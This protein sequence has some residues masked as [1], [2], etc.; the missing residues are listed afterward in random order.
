MGA[1]IRPNLSAVQSAQS[2]YNCIPVRSRYRQRVAAPAAG[3]IQKYNHPR[4]SP[5]SGFFYSRRRFVLSLSFFV[6]IVF[7]ISPFSSLKPF[8]AN[9]IIATATIRFRSIDA[10]MSISIFVVHYT[11]LAPALLIAWIAA[12]CAAIAW[13]I[14][15]VMNVILRL[16]RKNLSNCGTYPCSFPIETI[17]RPLIV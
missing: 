2:K 3:N 6:R 7:R 4:R 9:A 15:S 5:D 17:C 16:F 8:S 14:S 12:F 11:R 10:P 1:P 13:A